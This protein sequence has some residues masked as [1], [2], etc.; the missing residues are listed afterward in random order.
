MKATTVKSDVWRRLPVT[1]SSGFAGPPSGRSILRPSNPANGGKSHVKRWRRC[2]QSSMPS[3]HR[4]LAAKT[5]SRWRTLRRTGEEVARALQKR[6]LDRELAVLAPKDAMTRC[7][8]PASSLRCSAHV[9]NALTVH[10]LDA[11]VETYDP[12]ASATAEVYL[13]SKSSHQLG[14]DQETNLPKSSPGGTLTRLS[15]HLSALL[16]SVVLPPCARLT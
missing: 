15:A 1:P 13:S 7:C 9:N 5:A 10:P 16:V 3:L 11:F 12:F 6:N 4:N 2:M 8:I 14:L